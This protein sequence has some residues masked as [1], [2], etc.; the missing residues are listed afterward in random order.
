MV[1]LHLQLGGDHV[2]TRFVMGTG[3]GGGAG[4]V[5]HGDET[6]RHSHPNALTLGQ[7]ETTS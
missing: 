3:G 5:C 2:V 4:L 1:G 6:T 7:G